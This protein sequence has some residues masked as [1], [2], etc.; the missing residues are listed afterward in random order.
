M[1]LQTYLC[2]QFKMSKLT[3]HIWEKIHDIDRDVI[4]HCVIY[5]FS[6]HV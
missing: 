5:N 6:F 4:W 1:E 2:S 3:D